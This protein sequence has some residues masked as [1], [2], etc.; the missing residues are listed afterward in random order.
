MMEKKYPIKSIRQLK[1]P[2]K[3]FIKT[4]TGALAMT[5]LICI[6]IIVSATGLLNYYAKITMTVDIP[7]AIKV[8]GKMYTQGII[9]SIPPNSTGEFCFMHWMDS[10]ASIPINL[11]LNTTIL[12]GDEE[13][14]VTQYDYRNYETKVYEDTDEPPVNFTDQD[15]LHWAPLIL[16]EKHVKTDV[17]RTHFDITMPRNILYYN[18]NDDHFTLTVI[19]DSGNTMYIRFYG[20]QSMNPVQ[21]YWSYQD[22]V[23]GEEIAIPTWMTVN[24]TVSQK[25]FSIAIPNDKLGDDDDSADDCNLS[26][27]YSLQVSLSKQTQDPEP[28]M[29]ITLPLDGYIAHTIGVETPF[30]TMAA[31]EQ[32]RL[33]SICY[34]FSGY[35]MG[36]YSTETKVELKK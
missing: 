17:N 10:T 20:N 8:D 21:G 30:I 24:G 35:A 15:G 32:G 26:Y 27:G 16:K 36:T 2:K 18:N 3:K 9:D 13:F 23:S 22:D 4:R 33:F 31:N 14:N 6:S 29:I 11:F 28:P 1:Q 25:E 19:C 12:A 5:L 7:Q 34:T